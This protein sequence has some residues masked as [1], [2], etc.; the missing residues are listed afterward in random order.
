MKSDLHVSNDAPGTKDF[1]CHQAGMVLGQP[2]VR[3]LRPFA[4]WVGGWPCVYLTEPG[5][6]QVPR[7]VDLAYLEIQHR[8]P[9]CWGLVALSWLPAS[10]TA[11]AQ[12]QL[13]LSI[14]VT[15]CKAFR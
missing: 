13:V 7:V 14:H 9:T 1:L 10:V 2:R 5:L 6:I 15:E 12:D 4:P 8:E 11:V 3:P